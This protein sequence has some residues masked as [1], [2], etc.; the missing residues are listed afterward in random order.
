[1]ALI[2]API[3]ST[4]AVVIMILIGLTYFL[5]RRSHRT[6]IHPHPFLGT[7][8]DEVAWKYSGG[9]P[10][11]SDFTDSTPASPTYHAFHVA[12]VERPASSASSF[13]CGGVPVKTPHY[14]YVVHHDSHGSAYDGDPVPAPRMAM[15]EQRPTQALTVIPSASSSAQPDSN[16]VSQ[17]LVRADS[18]ASTVSSLYSRESMRSS[19]PISP[20]LPPP[21][22]AVLPVNVIHVPDMR[23][24]VYTPRAGA[25]S[26]VPET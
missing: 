2:A 10:T 13:A 14:N 22:A 1:M 21:A 18:A 20:P 25:G 4:A 3:A 15:E 23:D 17:S 5:R 7:R 8:S 26:R 24:W 16:L 6:T 19:S 12:V 11:R 9:T